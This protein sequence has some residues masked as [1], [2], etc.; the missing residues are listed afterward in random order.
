[1]HA[2][3]VMDARKLKRVAASLGA[4]VVGVADTALLAGIETEPKDLLEGFPRAVSLAVRLSDAVMDAITDRPTP[5]Y[6]AHYERAN[7]LLDQIS[8]GLT[9]AIQAAGGRALPLPASQVLDHE[10]L[11]SYISHKAVAVAAGVGWQGK[12][13][14]T[15]NPRFG[16]RIRLVS[17]LTDLPIA[18]DAPLKNRCGS[19][20]AC[21]TACPAQ[22]IRNVNTER[23]YESR[24]QALHFERCVSTIM[25][26]HK[27]LPHITSAICG[28][29]V[30]ACLWGR[31][32]GRTRRGR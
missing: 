27:K 2:V 26:E 32:A 21:S 24:E 14:L 12:S 23:H 11:T 20:E 7:I 3:E 19:C 9:Q 5:L 25:N 1:M 28:V 13:L 4:D 17:V 16:P 6:Q 29:C 31:K 18:P 8:L 22:A 30:A 10:K 15:V